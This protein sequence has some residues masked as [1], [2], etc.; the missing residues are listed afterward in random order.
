MSKPIV[1]MI[2]DGFGYSPEE[3]GNAIA[4]AKTPILDELFNTCPH[5]LIGASVCPT[6][7]WEIPRSVTPTSARAE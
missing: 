7:R 5:T 4:A 2:L 6:D 3:K 1:L